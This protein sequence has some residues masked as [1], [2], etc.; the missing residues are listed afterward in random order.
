MS[1][2][3]ETNT[4]P[5]EFSM[6]IDQI[7]SLTLECWRLTKI[8][9]KLKAGNERLELR[10]VVRSINEIL[11]AN[12]IEIVDYTGRIYDNGMVPEVVDFIEEE[13]LQSACTVV[14]ETISPTVIW[15][16][17]VVKVGKIVVKR[18][19]QIPQDSK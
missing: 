6:T 13:G 9:E 5:V 3:P 4:I 18:F 14:D 8:E 15:H 16:G 19:S 17:R 12:D 10:R 2:Q 1:P 7:C 11:Q